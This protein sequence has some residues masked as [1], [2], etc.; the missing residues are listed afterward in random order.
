LAVVAEDTKTIAYQVDAV[1]EVLAGPWHIL[2]IQ[3]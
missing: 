2:I 3:Q 1:V